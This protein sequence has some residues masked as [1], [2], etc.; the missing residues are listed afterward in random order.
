MNDPMN[1]RS[2]LQLGMAAGAAVLAPRWMRAQGAP[3]EE[4]VEQWR[5]SAL[6]TPIK[7][8]KLRDNIFLLEGGAGNQLLQTG[9]DGSLLIDAGFS[10]VGAKTCAAVSALSHGAPFALINTHWHFDHTGGNEA[11]HAAGFTIYAHQNTRKRLSTP[12]TMKFFHM[13][14]PASPA[15][16]LPTITFENSLQLWHNGD[17]ID[18]VHFAPAHTDSDLYVYFH[19]ADVLHLGDVWFNGAYPIIDESSGGSIGGTIQASANA[20]EVAGSGTRIISG[21]GAVGSKADLRSYHDMLAAVRDKVAALKS[22]GASEQ[23]AVAKKPTAEFDGVW[24]KGWGG[25][26]FT[27]MVYR[28]L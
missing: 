13:T 10:T 28:T 18:L 15:G 2:F 22:A 27:G 26:L 25:D 8:T 4:W 16:A 14:F 3:S 5:A 7:T 1:R 24:G 9:S 6:A 17:A 12:Q 19:R 21:H 11:L 20:L 23:E